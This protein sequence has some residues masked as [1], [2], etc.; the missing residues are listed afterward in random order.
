[1]VKPIGTTLAGL[2]GFGGCDAWFGLDG[3][4]WS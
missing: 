3:A 2:L 1:M 4:V